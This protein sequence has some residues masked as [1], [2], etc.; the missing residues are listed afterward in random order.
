M[1]MVPAEKALAERMKGRPFALLGVNGDDDRDRVK[2]V[3]AREGI[4]W[5]SFW[6]GGAQG[7]ITV[8]WGLRHWP[9]VY[10]ID[11]KGVIRDDGLDSLRNGPAFD[12]AI[13]AVVAEAEAGATK[14]RRSP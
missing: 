14:E 2:S 7:P 12:E 8:R 5:R 11:A 9:T 1:A 6:N 13:E 4:T 3:S 10:L